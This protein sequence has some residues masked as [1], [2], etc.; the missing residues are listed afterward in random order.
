VEPIV[1]YVDL[2]APEPV[3]SASSTGPGSGAP[4][5]EDRLPGAFRVELFAPGADPMDVRY[6]VIEVH[7]RPELELRLERRDPT[8]RSWGP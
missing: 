5:R 3:R 4:P 8:G 6:N 1:Y 2:A 7:R